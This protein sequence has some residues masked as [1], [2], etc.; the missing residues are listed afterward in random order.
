MKV[1][2]SLQFIKKRLSGEGQYFIIRTLYRKWFDS[3]RRHNY[4]RKI[5]AKKPHMS[6]IILAT[7]ACIH[8]NIECIKIENIN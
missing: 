2:Q 3:R 6:E 7:S 8:K 5:C 1:E 4:E